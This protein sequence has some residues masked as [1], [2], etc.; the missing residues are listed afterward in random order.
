LNILFRDLAKAIGDRASLL[1]EDPLALAGGEAIRREVEGLKAYRSRLD[2]VAASFPLPDTVATLE[3]ID[4]RLT[5]LDKILASDQ[6]GQFHQA[7]DS[8][9]AQIDSSVWSQRSAVRTK[10]TEVES[11]R[12]Q[13]EWDLRYPAIALAPEVPSQAASRASEQASYPLSPRALEATRSYET[14]PARW[15]EL[16]SSLLTTHAKLSA[17]SSDRT[18]AV[19]PGTHAAIPKMAY[20]FDERSRF[21]LG[22]GL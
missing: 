17:P 20:H 14:D 8:I 13:G 16:E 2:H 5:R 9:E 6:P 12:L 15:L 10:A 21:D 7:R 19:R 1:P 22:A 18:Q 3:S 4:H 11:K